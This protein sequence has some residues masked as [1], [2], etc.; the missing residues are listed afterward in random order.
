MDYGLAGKLAVVTGATRGIGLAIARVLTRESARGAV[1]DRTAP[2]VRRMADDLGGVA[3]DLGLRAGCSWADTSMV[4]LGT[5]G[6][7]RI[8][9]I[10][11][12]LPPRRRR[13]AS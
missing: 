8:I 13:S 6:W 9:T 7:G 1:V 4:E 5:G 10:G 2:D 3:N 11:S 12:L